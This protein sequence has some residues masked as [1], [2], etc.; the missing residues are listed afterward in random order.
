MSDHG[1]SVVYARS[2]RIF[3]SNLCR[4]MKL[5]CLSFLVICV[6]LSPYFF[7]LFLSTKSPMDS[8]LFKHLNMWDGSISTSASVKYSPKLCVMPCLLHCCHHSLKPCLSGTTTGIPGGPAL[9]FADFLPPS[10]FLRTSCLDSQ[11]VL[12]FSPCISFFYIYPLFSKVF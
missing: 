10:R 5:L 11:S 4:Y 2:Y 9:D 6:L 3:I 7:F 8:V 1:W 12:S